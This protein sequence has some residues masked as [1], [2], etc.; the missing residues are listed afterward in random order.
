MNIGDLIAETEKRRERD[1]ER[2]KSLDLDLCQ[3]CGAYGADKRTLRISYFYAIHESVPEAIDMC[4][5]EGEHGYMLRTCKVCRGDFL[6][7]LAEWR[8]RRLAMRGIPKDHDGYPLDDE[9]ANGLVPVRRHGMTVWVTE[10]EWR[11]GREAEA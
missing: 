11:E 7:M 2:H 6:A 1:A 10:E 3:L 4:G 5:L 8:E 9:D